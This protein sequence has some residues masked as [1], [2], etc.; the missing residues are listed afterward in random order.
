[1]KIIRLS[2]FLILS[3]AA[4]IFNNLYLDISNFKFTGIL[5]GAWIAIGFIGLY[6]GKFYKKKRGLPQ[7]EYSYALPDVLA[8]I[9]KRVDMRTQYESSILSMF[10][11]LLGLLTFSIYIVFISDFELYFKILTAANSFFG[12][13]FMFSYLVTTY[14]QYVNHMETT[15]A[16]GDLLGAA[17]P[18][19]SKE[20]LPIDMSLKE[21]SL[22]PSSNLMKGGPKKEKNE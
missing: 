6:V 11:M 21:L 5:L 8:K 18:G 3:V 12:M 1:M 7:E 13:I 15:K 16:I 19:G 14:Q 2:I 22:I 4:Y 17:L 9:M 20:L 10:F